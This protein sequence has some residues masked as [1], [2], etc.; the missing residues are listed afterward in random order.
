MAWGVALGVAVPVLVAAVLGTEI[1]LARRG[2]RVP[3]APAGVPRTF[4]GD[5]AV[6]SLWLG[7][8]TAAGVG[9]DQA[10][11]ALPL[12][13]A[14]RLGVDPE[15]VVVLAVSGDRVADVVSDQLPQISS[16][17]GRVFISVGANDT[18][19]L[20]SRRAFRKTYEVLV[21]GVRRLVGP[22][23]EIVVLGVPDMGAPPRLAQPLRAVAGWHG[24]RLDEEIRAVAASTPGV[25]YVPIAAATGPA[26]R[27]DPER[28]FADDR[29]HPSA[30]GYGL[31]A[32]AVVA[33]LSDG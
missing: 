17:V 14:R 3:S 4:P 20:S 28:F 19:H 27:G 2:P 32:D 33:A 24:R 8:S 22:R 9:V 16:P 23:V 10:A 6:R 11:D 31:W 15:A 13:V 7:D 12:Q 21:R 18:T 5:R 26:F 30:A 25:T 1:L 29:Y